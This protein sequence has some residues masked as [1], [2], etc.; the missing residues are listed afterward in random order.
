RV[1]QI[2]E[3]VLD[4]H[5]KKGAVVVMDA[6][7][8]DILALASRPK[9]HPAPGRI[10]QYLRGEPGA[11][12]DQ[13]V[14]LFAPGSLFKVVVAAAA[15][16]ERIVTPETTF[17]CRGAKDWPVRCWSEH[18]HGV[19]SFQEAFAQSCNPV[20]ARLALE[21]GAANLIAYARLFGLDDQR[22]AGYPVPADPRQNLDLIAAPHNLVNS[23]LGQ[24]PVLATPVQITAMMN[25]VVNGGKY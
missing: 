10:E 6:R 7:S 2:V 16:A 21:L 3:K 12:L 13:C 17:Y 9:Y 24:G 22:I 25:T 11:L 18:G 14:G 5:V 15:L 4:A 1:Q 23:S 19:I 20:F 8:G